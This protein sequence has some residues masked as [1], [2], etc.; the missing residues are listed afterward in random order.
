[1]VQFSVNIYLS[2]ALQPFVGPWPLFQFL[3]Q[4]T[5]GRTPWL[6][7]QPVVRHLRTHRTTQA[8][9]KRTQ[10]SML[11]V[12][13]EPTISAFKRAKTIHAL[14]RAAT[15][16][17]SVLIY[18]HGNKHRNWSTQR[19]APVMRYR[20]TNRAT[21]TSVYRHC[22]RMGALNGISWSCY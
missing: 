2:V 12:G 15:V 11:W 3:D 20:I 16:I 9:N 22:C 4:Y 18:R 5:V 21:S 8:Q 13:F 17:G 19:S 1:M 6:G 10:T 14:A 7:D